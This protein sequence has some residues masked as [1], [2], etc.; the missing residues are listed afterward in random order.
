MGGLI[1]RRGMLGAL[2]S[3]VAF[4][5]LPVLA[6]CQ[7][8]PGSF[9]A[10]DLTGAEYAR[11]LRLQD[12]QGRWRTL[13]EFKGR[14]VL[15]FFGFTQCP[16][17]CPTALA[18][19][20][21]VMRLLGDDATRLQ[22]IFVSVDPER[23]SAEL[24]REYTAAFHPSFLGLRGD[25]DTTAAVARDFKVFYRKVPTGSSYTLDHTALSYAYD[26][27]GRLR[28]AI[29]HEAPATDVAADLRRLL[30]GA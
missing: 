16:D 19:A 24:L 2:T 4:V 23:D 3:V 29:R 8:A 20:V 26:P 7:P 6:G 11:D 13:S 28:L 1:V 30:Q 12:P 15:L 17:V 14:V 27:A 22:V 5:L 9:L 18:R 21:E 25:L 10:T